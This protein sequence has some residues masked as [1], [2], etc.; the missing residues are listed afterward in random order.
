MNEIKAGDMVYFYESGL[1]IK[2]I[3]YNYPIIKYVGKNF[4]GTWN[5]ES[6]PHKYRIVRTELERLVWDIPSL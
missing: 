1:V 6:Y 3:H 2:V 5:I 4:D